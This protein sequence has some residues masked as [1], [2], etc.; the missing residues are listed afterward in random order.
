MEEDIPIFN[1]ANWVESDTGA[2]TQ[3]EADARYLIKISADTATG[4]QTFLNGISTTSITAYGG[5]L[6]LGNVNSTTIIYGN[7]IVA[8]V[9]NLDVADEK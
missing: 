2:L 3:Q 7:T 6:T 1:P 8:N 9:S 5:T 4:F